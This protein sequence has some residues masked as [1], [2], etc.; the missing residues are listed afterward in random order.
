MFYI[1]II[2]GILFIVY[3]VFL[4]KRT[5]TLPKDISTSETYNSE[6]K[7]T[8]S[9]IYEKEI[10][11]LKER[12]ESIEEILFSNI[13]EENIDRSTGSTEILVERDALEKYKIIQKYEKQGKNLDEIAKLL[14]INKGEVLLLKNLYKNS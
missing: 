4:E 10:D 9:T 13:L 14:D 12:L 3:G 7:A 8:D 1:L 11:G 5:N 6:V 2:L